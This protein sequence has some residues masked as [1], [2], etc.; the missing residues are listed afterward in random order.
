MDEPLPSPPTNAREDKAALETLAM[1]QKTE[2][3]MLHDQLAD[4]KTENAELKQSLLESH[5]FLAAAQ[6]SLESA[7]HIASRFEKQA[8]ESDAQVSGLQ[9]DVEILQEDLRIKIDAVTELE[10]NVSSRGA[11]KEE[12]DVST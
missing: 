5:Q 1:D 12:S 10:L 9:T 3:G 7:K 4:T 2:L 6:S 11:R 8:Q